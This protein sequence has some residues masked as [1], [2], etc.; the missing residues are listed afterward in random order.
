[1]DVVRG[2][3]FELLSQHGQRATYSAVAGFLGT[4]ARTLMQ[5]APRTRLYSWV[6]SGKTGMPTGYRVPELDPRLLD[7][8]RVIASTE[9]LREWVVAHS[10]PQRPSMSATTVLVQGNVVSIGEFSFTIERT[11][12]VPAGEAKNKLPPSLGSFPV[13][14]VDD[15]ADRVPA[16][17][18]EHGGV[19]F[20]MWQREA[21]WI[22]FHGTAAVRVAA[23]TVCAVTGKPWAEGLEKDPQNYCAAGPGGQRWI[24]GFK[25]GD[26]VVR[27]FVA[28]PLGQGYTVE[29]QITGKE[30]HGGFQV[31][32]WEPKPEHRFRGSPLRSMDFMDS[33]AGDAGP[34]PYAGGLE[35]YGCSGAVP[36]SCDVL[37]GTKSI[38]AMSVRSSMRRGPGGQS[39]YGSNAAPEMTKAAEMGLAAGGM[40]EQAIVTDPFGFDTWDL[41]K[42]GRVFVHIV[43]SQM[44]EAITGQKP[45][46]T[47]VSAQSY[48][49]HGYPWFSTYEEDAGRDV[50]AQSALA[51]IKDTAAIDKEK[52]FEGQ[53]DD[54]PVAPEHVRKI[55]DKKLVR[56][57]KW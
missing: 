33:G 11:L 2:R 13:F 28:M 32:A 20:P 7:S 47:P 9:E 17:W 24:D 45:P 46:S 41:T 16:A 50:K 40:I 6:V 56:D 55:G 36:A 51:G 49:K 27:Q 52:G 1:M 43:N 57:G 22:N 23:G 48:T 21:A 37:G 29:K 14:K 25:T 44:F 53:Q 39:V 30:E 18:R 15:F 19:F 26:G 4:E 42:S 5:G 12:R 31:Q 34:A 3:I 35:A 54:T 10:Q 8:D 38:K